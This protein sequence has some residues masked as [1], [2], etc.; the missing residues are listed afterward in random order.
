MLVVFSLN[1]SP[2]GRSA[3][4]SQLVHS[5]A[6]QRGAVRCTTQQIYTLRAATSCRQVHGSATPPVEKRRRPGLG[7]ARLERWSVARQ[8]RYCTLLKGGIVIVVVGA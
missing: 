6:E 8:R 1:G 7:P 4:V 5:P 2:C 3:A